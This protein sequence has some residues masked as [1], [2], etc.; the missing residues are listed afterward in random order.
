MFQS[1]KKTFFKFHNFCKR[2]SFSS[3]I[4]QE[5]SSARVSLLTFWTT[6]VKYKT[7]GVF[8]FFE[9]MLT[10]TVTIASNNIFKRYFFWD[11]L[12]RLFMTKCPRRFKASFPIYNFEALKHSKANRLR[13]KKIFCPINF[14]WNVFKDYESTDNLS[15]SSEEESKLIQ[16]RFAQIEK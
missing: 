8:Q 6:F 4:H 5:K 3:Q 10:S 16:I 9:I 7:F 12:S 15:T 11:T 14:K 1:R 2:K 13:K